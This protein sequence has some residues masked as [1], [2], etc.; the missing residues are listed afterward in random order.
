MYQW[1]AY[2]DLETGFVAWSYSPLTCPVLK[3]GVLSAELTKTSKGQLAWGNVSDIQS[4]RTTE[5][6]HESE[7]YSRIDSDVLQSNLAKLDTA[8]SGF[9]KH[10]R[11]FPAFRKASNFKTFQYKPGRCK[12]EVNRSSNQKKCYSHI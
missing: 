3:H 9:F 8:Y 7:W 10:K 2:T 5:L 11:G 12:F 4:K 6:R 1:G